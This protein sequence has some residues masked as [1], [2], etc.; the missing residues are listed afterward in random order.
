MR[1]L[2]TAWVGGD[3]RAWVEMPLDHSEA[4]VCRDDLIHDADLRHVADPGEVLRGD[5]AVEFSRRTSVPYEWDAREDLAW[6]LVP[7]GYSAEVAS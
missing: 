2:K 4:K 6:L 7:D 5:D 3:V 1:L